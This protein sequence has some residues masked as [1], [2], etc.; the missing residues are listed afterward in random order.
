M[1]I[2]SKVDIGKVRASNQDAANAFI[3]DDNTA[4]AVVCDGM[5]GASGGDVASNTAVNAI[6]DYVKSSYHSGMSNDKISQLL[7]NA[8]SSANYEIFNVSKKDEALRGMG[9]TVVAAIITNDHAIVYHVGDSRAYLINDDIVQITKDHSVVQ[10]LIESG[11]LTMS[12]AKDFPEKNVITRALGVESNVIADQSIVPLNP[13]DALL[14]CSDG[15][16]N[17]VDA[18]SILSVFKQNRIEDVADLLVDAANAGG[19]GDNISVV[20]VSK[21]RG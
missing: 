21:E 11:K 16:T 12:E 14:L 6:S 4:F 19:G 8:V 17:F 3:I 7:K 13:G 9:T 18:P 10:S 1:Q 20:I 5:G 2:F 15:L